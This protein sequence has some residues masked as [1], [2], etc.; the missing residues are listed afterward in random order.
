LPGTARAR[1][2]KEN[3]MTQG[4]KVMMACHACVANSVV[5]AAA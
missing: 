1:E 2:G 5:M 4:D 3:Q